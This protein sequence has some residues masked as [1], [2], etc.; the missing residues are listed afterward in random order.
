ML[1]AQSSAPQQAQDWAFLIPSSS[2]LDHAVAFALHATPSAPHFWKSQ[3]RGVVRMVGTSTRLSPG[4]LSPPGGF[5]AGA[6]PDGSGS[7]VGVGMAQLISS[8]TS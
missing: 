3:S 4:T 1:Q 6:G 8:N 2:C 5:S 7:G